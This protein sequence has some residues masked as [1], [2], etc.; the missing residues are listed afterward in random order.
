MRFSVPELFAVFGCV[1]FVA[2]VSHCTAGPT[3]KTVFDLAV[4]LC[5]I[6]VKDHPELVP[7][8]K[9]V[10]TI[11]KDAEFLQP[12]VDQLTSAQKTAMAKTAGGAKPAA[13]SPSLAPEPAVP[14]D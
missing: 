8:G 6:T 3:I 13:S 12:F 1:L 4:S 9:A 10:D 5:E 11:C 7:P 14:K 2:F